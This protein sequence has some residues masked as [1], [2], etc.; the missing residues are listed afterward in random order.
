MNEAEASVEALTRKI[1]RAAAGKD[2]FGKVILLDLGA[3]GVIRIDGAGAET[4]VD[5]RPG[6]AD[7]VI[8]LTAETLA[9]LMSGAMSAP[10]AVMK[11][12][13]SIKGDAS[14]ALKLAKFL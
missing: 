11:G 7:A 1:A 2:G 14:L 8:G 3:D 9:K 12:R 5:N 13:V 4:A 10:V 6:D